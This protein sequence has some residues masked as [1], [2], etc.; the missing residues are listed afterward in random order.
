MIKVE[1]QGRAGWNLEQPGTADCRGVLIFP[2][3]VAALIASV[4]PLR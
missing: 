4:F 1:Q 3:P 2:M